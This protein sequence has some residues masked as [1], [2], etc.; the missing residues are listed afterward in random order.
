MP[1]QCR[2]LA[3]AL[4][5]LAAG[6]HGAPWPIVYDQGVPLSETNSLRSLALADDDGSIYTGW[7]LGHD[8][9]AVYRH[10]TTTGAVIDA[11][12]MAET[13]PNAIATD[14]RGN[15][16]IATSEFTDGAIEIRTP[17][18]ALP[19]TIPFG[20]ETANASEG[21][22][23]WQPDPSTYFLYVSRMNGTVQRYNVTDPTAP[24]LD[25][26]WATGGTFAVTG[27]GQLR[28]LD[29]DADGTIYVTQRDTL[30]DDRDGHV[31]SITPTFDEDMA[32]LPGGMDV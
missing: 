11:Y 9:K 22:D 32:S 6:V 15:V 5:C 1:T 27:A 29:V 2:L 8:T 14:N 20:Q 21:L 25:I 19:L 17:D 16:Y 3:I 4:L 30:S 31:Y 10:S 26:T 23:I 12:P 24:M 7:I 18:L 13:Q 28:G